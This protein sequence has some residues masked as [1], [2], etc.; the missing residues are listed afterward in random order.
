MSDASRTKSLPVQS[1]SWEV[2]NV[3]VVTGVDMAWTPGGGN[4][5]WETWGPQRQRSLYTAGALAV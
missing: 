2:S 4:A 1:S 5:T 3:I